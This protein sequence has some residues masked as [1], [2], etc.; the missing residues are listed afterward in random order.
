MPGECFRLYTESAFRKMTEFDTPE[1][2]RCNLSNAVLQLIAMRQDPFTFAYIDPPSR[3]SVAA[4][5]R[6]LAGLGAIS[7]PTEITPLGR[8]MLKYPLDPEHARILVASFELGCTA[9]IIDI[10]S[11]VVTGSVFLDR[12][13]DSRETAAAARAKFIHRDGDHLTAMNVLRAYLA[14]K[15][16]REDDDDENEAGEESASATPAPSKGKKTGSRGGLA[17]WC[18]D[19]HVNGKTLTAATKVRAQLRELAARHGHDARAS[20]GSEYSVVGRALLQGLFMNTAVIQSDGSYR[21]SAGS[22]TVKIHPSSVL[23]GR[24]VP[25]IVYDELVSKK[26]KAEADNCRPS[27]RPSTRAMCLRSSSTGSLRCRGLRRRRAKASRRPCPGK[28]SRG[29]FGEH[30]IS[31]SCIQWHLCIALDSDRSTLCRCW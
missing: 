31:Y 9:E 2:Q 14:L 5:F 20:C 13:Q 17:Q 10:L 12:A 7:S 25:A 18:R 22:L 16:Q 6:S 11:L 3:D 26:Q 24:K 23:V 1:I 27:R 15:E 19:N 28:R 29:A 8:E 30:F 21:Q 4:A